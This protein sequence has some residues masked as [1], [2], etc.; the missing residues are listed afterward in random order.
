LYLGS[1]SPGQ[2][3]EVVISGRSSVFPWAKTQ[4]G[5]VFTLLDKLQVGDTVLLVYDNRQYDYQI[6]RQKV[7]N[8]DQVKIFE[9]S[10]PL[11]K[12]TTW[13]PRGTLAKRL[14][15]HGELIR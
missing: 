5:R 2:A 15:V 3:E 13:W 8:P 9:T 6:T 4:Y 7:L 10:Q 1:V 12:I 14:V 11:L